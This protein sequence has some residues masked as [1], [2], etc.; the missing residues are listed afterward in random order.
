MIKLTN[1]FFYSDIY[2]AE[3]M[4]DYKT[5]ATK[6]K[7]SLAKRLNFSQT[8]DITVNNV[9]LERHKDKDDSFP[10]P[11]FKVY[12]ETGFDLMLW[13]HESLGEKAYVSEILFKYYLK[14]DYAVIIEVNEYK[15]KYSYEK[16]YGKV[17]NLTPSFNF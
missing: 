9:Y 13:D 8:V 4:A 16:L 5:N 11:L 17:R 10:H 7:L 3:N 15:N 1:N 6:I 2:H 14:H 12:D